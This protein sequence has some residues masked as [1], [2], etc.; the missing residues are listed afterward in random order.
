M[1]TEFLDREEGERIK[2]VDVEKNAT[3]EL[4]DED[5]RLRA[6]YSQ[7]QDF[8]SNGSPMAQELAI[9]LSSPYEKSNCNI[10]EWWSVNQTQFPLLAA[11]VSKYF[12]IQA[13]RNVFT[14][15]DNQL[16]AD[17]LNIRVYLKENLDKV[18]LKKVWREDDPELE[19]PQAE[20]ESVEDETE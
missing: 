1:K 4:E 17:N 13:T 20:P 6:Q 8:V 5:E 19:P 15:Q 3:I 7:R 12:A 14:P 18:V 9:Y 10:L 11:V 16:D 2:V